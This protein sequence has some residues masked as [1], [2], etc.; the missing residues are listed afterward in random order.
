[1]TLCVVIGHQER[2]T[3]GLKQPQKSRYRL[4]FYCLFWCG[5]N[6]LTQRYS[7]WGPRPLESPW[8]YYRGLEHF[9]VDILILIPKYFLLIH[10][11]IFEHTSMETEA[12]SIILQ[13]EMNTIIK[14]ADLPNFTQ[15]HSAFTSRQ[16]RTRLH[17]GPANHMAA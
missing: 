9:S 13:S 1:M 17:H 14:T 6:A 7:M 12:E 2:F 4:Q 8:R 16:R 5:L 11:M 15:V 10:V 3:L